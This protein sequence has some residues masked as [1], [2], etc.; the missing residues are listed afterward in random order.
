MLKKPSPF[1]LAFFLMLAAGVFY[2]AACKLEDDLPDDPHVPLINP[3][4]GVWH[5]ESEYWQFRTDGTG[6]RA[7]AESGPFGN[8]F[9][10]FIYAG[11]DVQ[12]A[13]SNGNL[14]IL[15][16]TGS[17]AVTRY[18]FT[19]DGNNA[20]LENKS[21]GADKTLV[22]QSGSPQALSLTN[23]L[24]GEWSADWSGSGQTGDHAGRV[25][26]IKYRADGTVKTYHH[27]VKHQFENGY[28]LRENT[29]V[30][31]G[32][33]RFS[34]NPVIAEISIIQEGKWEAAEIQTS[35]GP[36]E[37]EYT[38]VSEAQWLN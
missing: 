33:M 8:N 20:V 13:P 36:A 16:G 12:S 9:S 27:S 32:Y 19:I 28:A 22:R 5:T 18:V 10:F 26:S 3:F 2:I 31:F 7:S 4:I 15:D 21:G 38:R 14:I 6:G 37:W 29:L 24:I 11:Q 17:I 34:I 25:W 35:P 23:D 1:R 30:I